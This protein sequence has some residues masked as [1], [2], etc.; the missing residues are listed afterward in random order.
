MKSDGRDF[1]KYRPYL[2]L[3]AQLQTAPRLRAK[4]DLSGV[5]QQTMLDA[6][7]AAALKRAAALGDTAI[8][9]RRIL[10]RNLTDEVRRQKAEKRDLARE[11]SIDQA[12]EHSA[13]RLQEWL[14]AMQ[15]SP[16]VQLQRK[17][18]ELALAAALAEL[19]EANRQ[20]LIR[21]YLEGLS[22]AAIA[23]QLDRT[24]AAVAGLL[25]RGLQ[26]LRERLQERI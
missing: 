6:H 15:S 12:M 21:R 2:Q 26:Q 13:A 10:A 16:S 5:V 19:P 23:S 3:L 25:K 24:P 4:V 20:A 11:R 8:W 1:E 14:G 18:N 7:Q 9:L 17:E 22:L